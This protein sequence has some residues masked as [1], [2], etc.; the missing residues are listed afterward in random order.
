MS[1]PPPPFLLPQRPWDGSAPCWP[2][3]RQRFA[4][5]LLALAAC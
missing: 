2:A 5:A 3:V 4:V 1:Q